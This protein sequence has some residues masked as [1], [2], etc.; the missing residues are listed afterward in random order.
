MDKAKESSVLRVARGDL[1]GW[2]MDGFLLQFQS[3]PE[4][5]FNGG[6]NVFQDGIEKQAF[7]VVRVG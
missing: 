1:C 2:R 3:V 6:M 5:V 7:E 4:Q